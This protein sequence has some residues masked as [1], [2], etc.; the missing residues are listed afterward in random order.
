MNRINIRKIA[1]E[2]VVVGSLLLSGCAASL[3]NMYNKQIKADWPFFLAY[4]TEEVIRDQSKVATIIS[5]YGLNIDGVEVNHETKRSA[6]AKTG[7]FDNQAKMIVDVLPGEY[8]VKIV[9]YG[10]QRVT[11][12][13]MA[14]TFE[15][16]RIY[17]IMGAVSVATINENTSAD[18]AQK[19]SANRK[20]SV[21]GK[22]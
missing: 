17:D 12:E 15:A 21:F 9:Y 10:E 6:N 1:V 22:K 14:Y 11:M 5:F 20:N 19:I 3:N 7:R 16:G 2:M 13:S 4:D 18:V 8:K